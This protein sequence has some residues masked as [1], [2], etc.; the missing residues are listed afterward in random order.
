MPLLARHDPG[1]EGIDH[2]HAGHCN[3][4]GG[5]ERIGVLEDQYDQNHAHAQHHIHPRHEDLAIVGGAGVT[6]FHA[7]QLSQLHGLLGHGEDAGDHGLRGNDGGQSR[8][9]HHRHMRPMRYDGKECDIGLLGIA[10]QGRA[11]AKVI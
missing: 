8:Q 2:H 5:G 10:Q 1:I 11:L 3:A 6:D 4:I 9:R 7:R